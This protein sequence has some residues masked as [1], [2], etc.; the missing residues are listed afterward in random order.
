[1]RRKGNIQRVSRFE[2]KIHNP[3]I[4]KQQVKL[5]TQSARADRKEEEEEEE[6]G[7][8]ER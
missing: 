3:R 7:S 4:V 5:Q 8:S 1:M 2:M 6:K